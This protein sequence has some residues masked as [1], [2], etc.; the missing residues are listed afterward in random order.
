MVTSWK[1]WSAL[2]NPPALHPLFQRNAGLEYRVQVRLPFLPR[3][4]Q[5]TEIVLIVL[6]GALLIVN[7]TAAFVVIMLIPFSFAGAL[8]CLP[9]LLP[10]LISLICAIWSGIMGSMIARERE[11]GTYELL[12]LLPDGVLG[13]NWA[14]CS[15]TVHRSGLFDMLYLVVRTIALFGLIILGISIIISSGIYIGAR[16]DITNEKVVEALRT[17][18]DILALVIGY[19]VHY[20]QSVAL[21]S[22]VG[23]L[24]PLYFTRPVEVRLIAPTAFLGAQTITYAVVYMLAF[25]VLPTLLPYLYDGS[26][27][28]SIFMPPFIALA[29]FVFVREI[30]IVLL[31]HIL[32]RHFNTHPSETSIMASV[33]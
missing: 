26:S 15:G 1:L 31:W 6:L 16:L 4:G 12:C 8:I 27:A 29:V 14:I 18:M 7:P 10:L 3:T 22:L 17:L 19:H 2:H 24:T 32:Q 9:L 28:L 13:A 30:I 23:I 25:N 20:I 11:K 21:S 5:W 33:A